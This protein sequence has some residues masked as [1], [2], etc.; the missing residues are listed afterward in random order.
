MGSFERNQA[1]YV[2]K[3]YRVRNWRQYEAGLRNRGSLTV[4]ISEEEL[5]AWVPTQTSKKRPGGQEKYS[6]HAIETALTVGIVFHLPLR[7]T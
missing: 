6:N 1:K 5:G 7:Q 2:N 4:W 3:L